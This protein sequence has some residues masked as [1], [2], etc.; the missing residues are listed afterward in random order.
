V[1]LARGPAAAPL[2]VGAAALGL[3]LLPELVFVKDIYPEIYQR[4]NTY[5]KLT[6]QAFS[7]LALLSGV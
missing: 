2:L 1:S 5:F 3:V 7:W 4:G 6:Y